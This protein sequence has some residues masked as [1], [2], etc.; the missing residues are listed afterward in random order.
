MRSQT[1]T[2]IVLGVLFLGV[3]LSAGCFGPFKKKSGG[4]G[5][6]GGGAVP[7]TEIEESES[8]TETPSSK[9][10]TKV[11]ESAPPPA[12]AKAGY[13]CL[14]GVVIDGFTGQPVELSA[15]DKIFV[16]IRGTK[17]AASK[18]DDANLV[19]QYYICDIPLDETYSVFGFIDGYQNFEGTVNVASTVGSRTGA[20]NAIASDIVKKDPLVISNIVLFP[21]TAGGRDL[22]I[23]VYNQGI[24]VEGA[25]VDLEP[26]TTPS[27]SNNH[28]SVYG[29][30]FAY[31]N[32]TRNFPQRL[33][34]DADG[35]ALFTADKISLGT[36]YNIRVTPPSAL[37]VTI[38]AVQNI[39]LGIS[40]ATV[41]DNNNY[42]IN[43]EVTD[44]NQA[45]R[46]IACSSQAETYNSAGRAIVIFNRNIELSRNDNLWVVQLSSTTA[47]FDATLPGEVADTDSETMTATITNGNMLTLQ[48]IWATQPKTPDFE[49]IDGVDP[50]NDD[51]NVIVEY[52]S[53]QIK[54]KPAGEPKDVWT[55]LDDVGGI[56]CNYNVRLFQAR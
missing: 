18:V 42:V 3:A 26:I 28:F 43:F 6:G 16:L 37:N 19:G 34:T 30:A 17:I 53:D 22:T 7:D 23:R 35:K 39:T 4:G 1:R 33:T 54:V 14:Q 31:S 46:V 10:A 44:S 32:G 27:A 38:P 8:E 15:P 51:R 2:Y 12:G 48:P 9:P 47:G 41:D 49:K 25:T 11:E 36:N 24:V 29:A 5:G 40:G 13:G 55:A 21:K 50:Q 20:A 56:A 52:P 45:L